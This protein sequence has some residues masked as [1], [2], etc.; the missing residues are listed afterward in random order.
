MQTHVS[1]PKTTIS[2]VPPEKTTQE[3]DAAAAPEDTKT[4]NSIYSFNTEFNL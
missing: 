3:D 4:M 1:G 2:Q